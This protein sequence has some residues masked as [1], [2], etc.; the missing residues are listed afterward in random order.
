[1]FYWATSIFKLLF[2]I[3][4]QLEKI[5]KKMF[6]IKYNKRLALRVELSILYVHHLN[7]NN[8]GKRINISNLS[9]EAFDELKATSSISFSLIIQFL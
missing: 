8:M 1:M 4:E 2:I 3:C 5:Y 9:L 6:S 7:T